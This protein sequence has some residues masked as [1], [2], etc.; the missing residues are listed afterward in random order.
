MDIAFLSVIMRVHY[1]SLIMEASYHTL[2]KKVIRDF[3]TVG[4]NHFI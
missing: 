3:F 4:M 1:G 2:L